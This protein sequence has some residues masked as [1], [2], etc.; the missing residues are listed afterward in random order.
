MSIKFKLKKNFKFIQGAITPESIN[1]FSYND[2][3]KTE[4]NKFIDRIVH[5]ETGGCFLV[6]GY[7]GVGKTSFVDKIIFDADKILKKDNKE[8]SIL[9]IKINVAKETTSENLM[10]Q[11]IR[12]LFFTI[13]SNDNMPKIDNDTREIITR[14]YLRTIFHFKSISETTKNTVF[15][16]LI[17]YGA[18]AGINGN[19]HIMLK[20]FAKFNI[21]KNQKNSKENL[22]RVVKEFQYMDYDEKATENDFLKIAEKIDNNNLLQPV[23]ILD[24]LDKL[25]TKTIE[26]HDKPTTKTTK[27]QNKLNSVQHIL[28]SLKNIFSCP[29][30][31]FI[32]IAGKDFYDRI[33]EDKQKDD[34]I[35]KSL[36]S[37]EFYLK[38][39][40]DIGSVLV[41]N[42][43]N[44]TKNETEHIKSITTYFIQYINY[45]SLGV[46]RDAIKEFNNF[47]SFHEEQGEYIPYIYLNEQDINRISFLGQLNSILSTKINEEIDRQYTS[48]E[49]DNRFF[50]NL[51]FFLYKNIDLL[52]QNNEISLLDDEL[53]KYNSESN[54]KK[55]TDI[56]ENILQELIDKKWIIKVNNDTYK[57]TKEKKDKKSTFIQSIS[58]FTREDIERSNYLLNEARKLYF[59]MDSNTETSLTESILE[60]L[61]EAL[62]VYPENKDVIEFFSNEIYPHIAEEDLSGYSHLLEIY[63]Q[64][65]TSEE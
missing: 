52:L 63:Y 5:T 57:L 10:H 60:N 54:D 7:R 65:N 25:T 32:I 2:D 24:E 26:E 59:T 58:S 29:G 36:F 33:E 41:K 39:E 23:F 15:S 50:D 42:Y 11:I 20:F 8:K 51:K 46:I 28:S 13:I 43:F 17:H 35:Y 34:S 9:K 27:E 55:P 21:Y 40:W 30:V 53:I 48:N 18:S 38:K 14:A 56:L 62:K 37:Y 16:N 45:K 22:E 61:N 49:K 64:G 1:R 31:I 44:N 6:T 19:A 4:K 3:Y 47:V 12:N